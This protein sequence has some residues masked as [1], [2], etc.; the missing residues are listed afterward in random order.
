M[1][2]Y[3]NH[4]QQWNLARTSKSLSGACQ[5]IVQF[6]AMVYDSPVITINECDL[7]VAIVPQLSTTNLPSNVFVKCLLT[8]CLA[9][10]QA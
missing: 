3:L 1:G 5:G 7:L 2:F 9:F 8:H 4:L 10:V 6:V